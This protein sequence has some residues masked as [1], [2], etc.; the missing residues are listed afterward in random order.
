M[1]I[2]RLGLF[3]ELLPDAD[4]LWNQCDGPLG[5]H[6]DLQ[7]CRNDRDAP[8]ALVINWPARAGP[9]GSRRAGGWKRYVYKALRRPTTPLRVREGYRWLDRP[10]ERTWALMY[11]PPSLVPDWLYDFT[12]EHCERVY[13]PD[14]RAT[15]PIV[16]PAMW[17]IEMDAPLLRALRPPDKPVPLVGVNAGRPAGKRLVAGHMVRLDFFARLRSARVPLEL[18]G[19]GLPPSLG[20]VGSIASKLSALMP[21]RFALVIENDDRED[22]YVTEKLWD[23]LLCWCLPLYFGPRAPERLLPPGSFVRLPDLREGGVEAVRDC[24]ARRHL[25]EDSLGAIAEARGRTL[26]EL[27]MVEWLSRELRED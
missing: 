13:G 26:G 4:L 23:A 5:R 15:H 10:R 11:E 8:H 17:T 6:G 20:A 9:G 19:R 12:R 14:D 16:L 7:L 21:A 1:S 3:H 22:R 18:F 25:W 2:R 27:R 24:L